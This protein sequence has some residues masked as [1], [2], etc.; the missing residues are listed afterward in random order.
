MNMNIWKII[1]SRTTRHSRWICKVAIV[2]V[3][4]GVV[5]EQKQAKQK[6]KELNE[7]EPFN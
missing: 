6:G 2:A 7:L 4:L 5:R 1:D 3:S